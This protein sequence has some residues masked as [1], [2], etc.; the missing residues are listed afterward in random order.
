MLGRGIGL[1]L[2]VASAEGLRSLG[3]RALDRFADRAW[4]RRCRP[5]RV[6]DWARDP[7]PVDRLYVLPFPLARSRGGVA[8]HL[9]RRIADESSAGAVAL[10]TRESG[11][12][13][14]AGF[15]GPGRPARRTA[16]DAAGGGAAGEV[17][18]WR[19]ALDLAERLC[20]PARLRIESVVGL[21]LQAIEPAR[22]PALELAVHDYALF[23]PRVHPVEV[24]AGR[25]CGLPRD[26]ER[27]ARCL[28][29]ERAVSAAG[30]EAQRERAARL[31]AAVERVEFPSEETRRDH[32]ALFPGLDAGRTEV[33]PP[34]RFASAAA[35]PRRAPASPLR[36]IALVGAAHRHKGAALFAEVVEQVRA[37]RSDWPGSWHV[38]GGGDPELLAALRALRGVRVHGY[39]R[40]G[41]LPARLREHRIDLALL[42]SPWPETYCLAVDECAEAGVP[43]LA[44]DLGAGAARIA[45][46]DL[47]ELVP[48]ESGPAGVAERIAAR[49]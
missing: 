8:H 44:F 47:G 48:L 28:A 11:D 43:M 25:F 7:S 19:G 3:E 32:L 40:A 6:A 30:V 38:L 42:L 24:P 12:F 9:F 35:P 36:R 33:R 20:P 5:V 34:E 17:A 45:R 31:L 16:W 37:R 41:S 18:A 39:Y 27:C 29:S 10:L 15:P 2:R 4:W 14:L 23:C 21:P 22:G 49:L 26:P 1:A 13:V 46:A